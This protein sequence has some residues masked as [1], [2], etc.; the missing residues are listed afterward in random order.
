[1]D[2]LAMAGA[3]SGP[4]PSAGPIER[5][6]FSNTGR[7]MHKW[8]HYLPLYDRYFGPY[9]ARQASMPFLPFLKRR[10]FPHFLEIGVQNGGSLQLWRRFFGSSAVIFG[11]DIDPACA[12]FDGEG[13]NRVRIGSQ[14][15]SAFLHGVVAEMGSL[16]IVVDDGSHVGRHQRTSFETLFP[17][18]N[19][20][21]LYLIEDLHTSY[22][23]H[24]EGSYS[25]QESAVALCKT[26]ID[27]LHHWYHP[28]GM[29]I[30][31]AQGMVAGLHIHDSMVIIEKAKV[32]PPV[33]SFRGVKRPETAS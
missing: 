19:E 12:E 4:S 13:G 24:F 18:L 2:Y 6:F 8:H 32:A 11:I 1:M 25:S 28:R 23:T 27:D 21:G 3:D 10:N 5:A 30:A 16:D 9:R 33:N 14:A 31:A 17:L 26:L 7:A 29:E 15:D 20:G 22:W